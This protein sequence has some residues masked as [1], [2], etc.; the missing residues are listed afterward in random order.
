[1]SSDLST[2]APWLPPVY[3]N[4]KPLQDENLAVSLEPEI[5]FVKFSPIKKRNENHIRLLLFVLFSGFTSKVKPWLPI[6]TNYWRVNVQ[7]Q[8]LEKNSRYH[9]YKTL[10]KLRTT[11]TIKFGGFQSYLV[12]PWV[13]AFSR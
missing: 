7:S 4:L 5:T 13:Y 12:A 2:K 1:M 10:S 11:K 3:K 9:L 8:K 6:N